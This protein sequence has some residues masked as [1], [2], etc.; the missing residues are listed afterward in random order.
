MWFV[1]N[2]HYY[3][4]GSGIYEKER[5][6]DSAWK[7]GPRDI[8]TYYTDSVRGNHQNDVFIVGSFGE[9][10][11][12][13]G[14]SWRSYRSETAL[15]NGNLRGGGVDVKGELVVAAGL[16]EAQAVILVGRRWESRISE[17]L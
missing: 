4:V 5:L 3:V 7:N 10:L 8:T 13:N 11:H 9:V 12:Y 16:D 1:P 6:S 2:R 17:Q 14:V 15:H